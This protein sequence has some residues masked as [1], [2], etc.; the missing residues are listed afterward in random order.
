MGWRKEAF[1]VRSVINQTATNIAG[2][3]RL[4]DYCKTALDVTQHSNKLRIEF[5]FGGSSKVWQQ[6]WAGESAEDVAI[7]LTTPE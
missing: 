3:P 5:V 6:D 1:D 4:T 7:L 2:S